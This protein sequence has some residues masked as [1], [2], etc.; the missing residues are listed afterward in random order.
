MVARRGSNTCGQQGHGDRTDRSFPTAVASIAHSKVEQVTAGAFFTLMVDA[1]GSIWTTGQLRQDGL[2]SRIF[3]RVDFPDAPGLQPVRF[4]QVSCTS[5]HALAVTT[6]GT[7]YSW[8][9]GND[10]QLGN[11]S[12]ESNDV[13]QLVR[14]LWPGTYDQIKVATR[15]TGN[16][17]REL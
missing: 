12:T 8:G 3:N 6:G 9:K 7:L 4:E 16:P 10:G 14:A 5:D 17:T 2:S 11:G 13:P 15:P 1:R